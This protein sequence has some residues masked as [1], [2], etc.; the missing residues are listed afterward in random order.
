MKNVTVSLD[1]DTY[2]KARIRAAEAGRSLS[3]LVREF[4][5]D[6]GSKQSEFERL[7]AEELAL[8][9]KLK[10]LPPFDAGDRLSRDEVHDRALMRRIHD[11]AR[12]R[13]R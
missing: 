13:E 7:H 1:D 10:T 6:L 12:E 11:E 5:Q 8:R 2:R 9:E 3:A 4:L